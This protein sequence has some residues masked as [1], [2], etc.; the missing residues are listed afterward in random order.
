M[1]VNMFEQNSKTEKNPYGKK[2]KKQIA[3]F[4]TNW[5]REKLLLI[6]VAL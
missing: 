3:S 5:G 6:K 2:E 4:K 1:H